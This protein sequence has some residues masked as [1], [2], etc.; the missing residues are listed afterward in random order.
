MNK[1]S[2]IPQDNSIFPSAN[3]IL[4]TPTEQ[5][6]FN[7][8]WP[9]GFDYSECRTNIENTKFYVTIL[10]Q[11]SYQDIPDNAVSQINQNLDRYEKLLTQIKSQKFNENFVKSKQSIISNLNISY[12]HIFSHLSNNIPMTYIKSI[13]EKNG[14]INHFEE[15]TK[16]FQNHISQLRKEYQ[17]HI[18]SIKN[19][20]ET[21]TNKINEAE[22]QISAI[23]KSRSELTENHISEL[24]NILQSDKEKIEETLHNAQT[25][26]EKINADS[27]LKVIRPY[28]LDFKSASDT[29]LSSSKI[30]LTCSIISIVLCLSWGIYCL[31]SNI[32]VG[33]DIPLL[34]NY[35]T[36]K[37]IITIILASSLIWCAR[38]YKIAL[39]LHTINLHKANALNS[40]EAFIAASDSQSVR[41]AVILQTTQ[42]IFSNEN[43]G[44]L[45]IEGN[46]TSLPALQSAL[47]L[48]A[49][50]ASQ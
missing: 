28:S 13:V 4:K 41:D 18:T 3:K 49:K 19:I 10:L 1:E 48:I 17:E 47:E 40:F 6:I 25:S 16:N 23:K 35:I 8:N 26:L 7:K 24:E 32:S 46:N 42:T 43:S 45:D 37:V 20:N 12:Q 29:H 34:V 5:I 38:R 36:S 44:Y 33:S 30:W 31:K 15:E 39:H 21:L 50:R 27:A 2:Q 14:A 22:Q 9:D 11:S